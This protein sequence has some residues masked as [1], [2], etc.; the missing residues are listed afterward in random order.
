MLKEMI[1]KVMP[2]GGVV[3]MLKADH[4]KVEGLFKEFEQA[5]DRRTKIRIIQHALQELEVHAALEEELIYPAIRAKIDDEE[6]MDEAVEE[7]HV[8]HVLIDELKAMQ[9]SD[10]RY[11]AKF[12]VLAESIKHHVKE[13]E[14]Q[15]LPKAEELEIDSPE[16]QER[17]SER[18]EALMAGGGRPRR[19]GRAPARRARRA[20][21]RPKRRRAA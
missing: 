10:D 14:S 11:D 16:F 18:K 12:K 13:E 20:G 1:S 19:R 8:A 17:V 2:S 21:G 6:I 7:H 15:V 5:K 9:S 3:G 4:R